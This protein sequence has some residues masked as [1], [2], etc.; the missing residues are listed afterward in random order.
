VVVVVADPDVGVDDVEWLLQPTSVTQASIDAAITPAT[1][2]CEI[3]IGPYSL[4]PS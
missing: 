3:L 1:I 2:V 4:S